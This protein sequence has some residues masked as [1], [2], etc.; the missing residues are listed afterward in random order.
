MKELGIRLAVVLVVMG[1]LSGLGAAEAWLARFPGES[2][3]GESVAVPLEDGRH[4]VAVAAAGVRAEG[5]RLWGEGRE[6]AAKVVVD[7]VSRLVV[8]RTSGAAVG[9]LPMRGGSPLGPGFA[10]TSVSGVRGRTAGWVR[11]VGGKVLPMS[12]LRV[13]WDGSRPKLGEAVRDGEGRLAGLC[14]EGGEGMQGYVLPVEVVQRVM[15]GVMRDGVVNRAWL[16][17]SLKPEMKAA[18]VTRVVEKSPASRAGIREG[19]ELIEVGGR[20]VRDYAD[21]VNAFYFLR[22][23]VTATVKVRRGG[24]EHAVSVTPEVAAK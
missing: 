17:L 16:G 14:G 13:V 10:V 21:A 20:V 5:G 9:V 24:Q 23:E 3:D 18:M 6:V 12:L 15:A 22:P 2:G 19:D 7:P 11:V 8:F 4:F 1:W